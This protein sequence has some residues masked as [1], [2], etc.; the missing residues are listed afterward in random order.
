[1]KIIKQVIVGVALLTSVVGSAALARG[2]GHGG[3]GHARVGIFLGVPLAGAAY[4]YGPRYYYPPYP[5]YYPG[6]YAGYYPYGAPVVA[7]APPV[8]VEQGQEGQQGSSMPSN[9]WYYCTNPQGYYPTVRECPNG[10]QQVPP[11]SQPRQ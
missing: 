2:H 10:W 1:M 3:H 5:G 9:Y 8:Y 7:A 11:Q 4:Y 6:Y